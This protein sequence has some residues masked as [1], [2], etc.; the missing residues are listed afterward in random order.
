[1]IIQPKI[2]RG[3]GIRFMGVDI[4]REAAIPTQK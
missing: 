2:S 3:K 4:S 1:M